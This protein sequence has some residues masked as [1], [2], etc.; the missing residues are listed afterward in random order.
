LLFIHRGRRHVIER[1]GPVAALAALVRQS[2]WVILDDA[3]SRAH[4][5]ALRAVA[6]LPSFRLA[7]TSGDL[8]T[9]GRTLTALMS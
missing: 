4:L 2:P 9:I 8:H 7:H 3:W 5:S 6:T 1:L